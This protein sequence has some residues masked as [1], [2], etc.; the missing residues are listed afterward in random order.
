MAIP[1]PRRM[2]LLWQIAIVGDYALPPV[3]NRGACEVRVTPSIKK[4]DK[5]KP[6][7]DKASTS[8]E[9]VEPAKIEIVLRF[10]E[11]IWEQVE[12][13]IR[14]LKPDGKP[15]DIMHPSVQVYDI[16]AMMIEQASPLEWNDG[17][18]EI[19]WSGEEWVAPAAQGQPVILRRGSTGPEVSRWQQFLTEQHF[20][21][22]EGFSPVDGIFG[23][24]TENGTKEFQTREEIKVDGIVGPETF[25]AASKFGYVPP[26]PIQGGG[27]G[28]Q[29]P[30]EAQAAAV[31]DAASDA[32][33]D[34]VDAVADAA[35]AAADAFL[36][37]SQNDEENAGAGG[38]AGAGEAAG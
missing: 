11:E 33:S 19:T 8:V 18:G 12:E 6:G 9:R 20:G 31:V 32:A 16:G 10:N 17:I 28:V 1:G 26:P 21:E 25:G 38:A 34:A 23:V 13:V 7:K 29:T 35:A 15:R 24:L 22:A 5:K 3:E 30:Q 37:G 14:G 27:G 2:P 36:G 4:D